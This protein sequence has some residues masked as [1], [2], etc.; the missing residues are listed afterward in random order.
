MFGCGMGLWAF[1]WV[2]G[3]LCVSVSVDH[4]SGLCLSMCLCL[5]L[6]TY[7]ILWIYRV[8]RWL[9]LFPTHDQDPWDRT[10]GQ[11]VPFWAFGRRLSAENV[12][13]SH[14]K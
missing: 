1:L 14:G 10:S 11:K 13:K 5:C 3:C 12:D 6:Y 2:C 7:L 8:F 9:G 4:E